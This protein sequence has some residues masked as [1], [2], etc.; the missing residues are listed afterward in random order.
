MLIVNYLL[1]L[2]E[3]KGSVFTKFCQHVHFSGA[4]FFR[5]LKCVQ[6]EEHVTFVREVL[7]VCQILFV[8]KRYS[9]LLKVT[10][11]NNSLIARWGSP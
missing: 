11:Q 7:R 5:F 4:K 2:E 3:F 8:D 6:C 9:S 1:H 10:S